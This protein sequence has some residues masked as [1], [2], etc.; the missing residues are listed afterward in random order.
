[1][2]KSE[3]DHLIKEALEMYMKEENERMEKELAKMDEVK[4]SKRHERRM[5]KL[6]RD[7]RKGKIKP[8]DL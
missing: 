8:A 1:M 6:F 3:F 5:K 2:T 4:F 7:L